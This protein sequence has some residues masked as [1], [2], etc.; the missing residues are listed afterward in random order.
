MDRPTFDRLLLEHLPAAQRFAA[1]LTGDAAAAEDVLHDAIVRAAGACDR[2]RGESRFTTWW[3]AII[4][5]AWRDRIGQRRATS[6]DGVDP[7]D[8]RIVPAGLAAEAG[9]LSAII[10]AHVGAL[11]PRQREAL[12]LVSLEGMPIAEAAAVLGITESNVRA[13]LSLARS[14]LR[15]ALADYLEPRAA[16]DE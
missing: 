14:R 6:V 7:P 11:P 1:R 3:F 8:S 2:F 9:E 10:A 13:N 4:L 15:A 5:N 16:R 12:V